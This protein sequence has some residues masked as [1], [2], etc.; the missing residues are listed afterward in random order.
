MAT[1]VDSLVVELGL[2][3]SKFTKGQK[4]AIDSLQKME[5][6]AKKRGQGIEDSAKGVEQGFAAV[7]KRLLGIAGLLL[8]GVGIEQFIQKMTKL[9]VTTANVARTFGLSSQMMQQWAAAGERVGVS[10]AAVQQG[11]ETIQQQ[12]YSLRNFG[13]PGGLLR[14]QWGTAGTKNPLVVQA[15]NGEMLSSDQIAMNIAK[16]L[17]KAGPQGAN[18]LMQMGGLSQ[19]FV[20]LLMQ[21]PEKLKN[22]LKEAKDVAP[23]NAEISR[24]QELNKQFE[25]ASQNAKRLGTALVA[26]ISPELIDFFNDLAKALAI[27]TKL[28]IG[29]PDAKMQARLLGDLTQ[30]KK[31][32]EFIQELEK[33]GVAVP[34]GTRAEQNRLAE[35]IRKLRE[36]LQRQEGGATFQKQSFLSPTGDN[37]RM[38]KASYG[39]AGGSFGG[40]G[41]VGLPM[42]TGTTVRPSG[43]GLD[44]SK[45]PAATNSSL[46]ASRERFAQELRDK[47]WLAEKIMAIS[48]GENRDPRANQAVIESMMNR[49]AVRGTTLEEAAKLY[50]RERGGYYAG[51]APQ[52]LNNARLRE[53]A[54]RSL[55]GALAGGNVS[56][57][58]TDNASGALAQRD[59]ASGRFSDMSVFNG[60]HFSRRASESAKYERW[61]RGLAA[62]GTAGVPLP[63]PRPSSDLRAMLDPRIGAGGRGG[64]SSVRNG[65]VNIDNIHIHAPRGDAESI[66]SAFRPAMQRFARVA[67]ANNGPA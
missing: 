28:I 64:A 13:D 11:L 57:Y 56:N 48:L 43:P 3:P 24:L 39:G 23:T 19:D 61:R 59:V 27:T 25:A 18:A 22:L 12:R 37:V 6:E 36:Q 34:E 62:H 7:Q 4:E 53:L 10:G 66:A 14:M 45:M 63:R 42:G 16:W 17:Q 55:K 65:D 5:G 52:A 33:K 29:S 46:A 35:E 47:P 32:D 15:P 51:Y 67:S 38:W 21:G 41:G 8:G 50:G 20:S 9:Q 58:A 2:D 60:E 40:G 44:L 54:E 49:A 31:I 26:M 1:I 30:K